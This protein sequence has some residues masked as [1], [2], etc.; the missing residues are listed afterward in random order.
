MI[1]YFHASRLADTGATY[2][3]HM[4][5]DLIHIIIPI[6]TPPSSLAGI[7]NRHISESDRADLVGNLELLLINTHGSPGTLHLGGIEEE[8]SDCD[9]TIHNY[10]FLTSIF[11]PL[12]KPVAEG[13]RGV[14]IHGCGVAASSLAPHCIVA[15]CNDIED[16]DVGYRFVYA[17]ACG[18]NTR[19]RASTFSEQ[20]ADYDGLFE[21]NPDHKHGD[22][23]EAL[24]SSDTDWHGHVGHVNV[25]GL[26]HEGG[27][28]RRL[29]ASVHPPLVLRDPRTDT[30]RRPLW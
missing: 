12:F 25:P 21:H 13:G 19:V 1:I 28:L 15:G 16:P 4:D 5:S 30:T 9:I 26:E 22:L 2:G 18:F 29:L 6:G 10:Q 14:E 7:V 23:I 3:R 8:N 27:T 20:V 24:P 17:L 11:R